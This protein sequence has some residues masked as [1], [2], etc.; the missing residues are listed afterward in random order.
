MIWLI[1]LLAIVL[2]IVLLFVLLY[3]RLVRCGTAST[4][5]GRR[6]RCSSSAAGT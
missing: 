1:V 2:A 3:N 4:T 6:W 5:P